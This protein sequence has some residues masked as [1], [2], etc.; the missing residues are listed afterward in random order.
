MYFLKTLLYQPFRYVLTSTGIALCMLL[1]LFLMGIYRGVSEGSVEY[2]RSSDVDLWVLQQ[3]A[4]NILRSTSLVNASHQSKLEN[5]QEIKS[6]SPVVFVLGSIR[7]PEGDQTVYLTGYDPATRQ[8]GPPDISKGRTVASDRE[9]VLDRSFADKNDLSV[10]DTLVLKKD[11]LTVVGLSNK[12]NMI[13]IQYAFVSLAQIYRYLGFRSVVSCYMIK[14]SS[15]SYSA[16][17]KEKI[18]QTIPDIAVFNKETFLKNNTKEMESGLLPLLFLVAVIG[19]I[20]LTAILSLI[21][22]INVLERRRDY[23][24]M[25]ALG[26]LPGFVIRLVLSQSITLAGT[27]L[28]LAI[29]IVKPITKLIENIA[30]EVLIRTSPIHI[31]AAAFGILMISLVS[32]LLPLQKLRKIYPLELFQ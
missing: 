7:L 20:V 32:T 16:Q 10:G 4:N 30:P 6:V 8:G 24:V 21:L 2:I 13:V 19:A 15:E 9:I 26:A 11:T 31:A 12:T 14:L 23:A 1:I 3:H 28:I 17:V 5:I 25:K 22:S 29:I 18:E 27:G